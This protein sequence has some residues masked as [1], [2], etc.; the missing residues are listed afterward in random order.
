MLALRRRRNWKNALIRCERYIVIAKNAV[1]HIVKAGC[2]MAVS[3]ISRHCRMVRFSL[4][5]MSCELRGWDTLLWMRRRTAPRWP[6]VYAV[7][8]SRSKKLAGLDSEPLGA[9]Y[10]YGSGD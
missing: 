10:H 9:R 8:R 3:A 7:A 2:P 1:V 5:R 4:T 6:I